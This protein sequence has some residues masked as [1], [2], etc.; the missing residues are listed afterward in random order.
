MPSRREP[1][2]LVALEAMACGLP[3]VASNEGGLPEFIS[4]EAGTLVSPEDE[5]AFC[6]AILE[7]LARRDAEPERHD[8]IARY[9]RSHFAQSQ[10]VTRLEEVYQSVI[11]ADA[12]S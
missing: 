6:G 12:Y 8:A 5:D 11:E 1:F 9:A 2:G 7:E 10:F 3:V 4:S